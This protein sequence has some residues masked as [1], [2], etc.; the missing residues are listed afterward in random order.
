MTRSSLLG[1]IALCVA[2]AACADS[3]SGGPADAARAKAADGGEVGPCTPHS[4]ACDGVDNDCDGETDEGFDQD[5]DGVTSCGGDCDD[6]SASVRPG[7]PEL[8]N[9]KDDDCDGKT[10]LHAPGVDYDQDGTPHPEDCNDENPLVGPQAAEVA[11]DG[12]DNDCDGQVD[13]PSADC[14]GQAAGAD[15]DSFARAMEICGEIEQAS[16]PVGDPVSRAIRTGFGQLIRPQRGS[17]MIMLTTGQALD[18]FD[19]QAYRPQDGWDFQTSQA[20]PLWARPRCGPMDQIEPRAQDLSELTLRL[21]VPQNAKSFTF[22]FNFFSAEYPEFVCTEYNDRFIVILES[23]ALD[24]SKLPEGNCL[25]G[26]GAARCNISYDARGQ[27]MT[28]NNGFFDVCVDSAINDCTK[29][30]TDLFMTGYEV[31]DG[32]CSDPG[33]IAGGATGWLTTTAPVTPGETIT[34]RFLV[35]DEGDGILDSAVL[36]DNFTWQATAVSAPVTETGPN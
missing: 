30:I 23:S 7:A 4:E 21:K 10:D 34:L 16:F 14:E 13:E 1:P 31:P 33:C 6:R 8:A 28:I 25:P 9:G 17:K 18:V 36:I 11:G 24:R 12:T 3:G 2:L 19:N 15:A 22:Q 35:L 29:P 27:P 5:G 26:A 32:D 20:H